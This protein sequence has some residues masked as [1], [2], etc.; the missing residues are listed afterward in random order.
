M[1]WLAKYLTLL[2]VWTA[3]AGAT[4]NQTPYTPS[5]WTQDDHGRVIPVR[6]G[7]VYHLSSNG[8][9]PSIIILD[10]GKDVE[11]IPTFEVSRRRGDTSRLEMTYSETRSLLDSYMVCSFGISLLS[12]WTCLMAKYRAMG[13]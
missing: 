7:T 8:S 5:T 9:N 10:Y 12:L 3:L 2:P 4:I 1:M 11:G 6:N 13:L